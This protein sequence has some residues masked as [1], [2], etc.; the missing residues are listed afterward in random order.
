MVHFK[1]IIPDQDDF[2]NPEAFLN[3]KMRNQ[4]IQQSKQMTD[5]DIFDIR[6][7]DF[8]FAKTFDDSQ[9]KKGVTVITKGIGAA[10]V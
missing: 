4:I 9:A 2:E 10:I 7:I 1:N 6:L 5:K 3:V 8:G